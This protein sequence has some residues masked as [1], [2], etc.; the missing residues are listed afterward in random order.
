MLQDT[1]ANASVS[2]SQVLTADGSGNYTV[3]VTGGTWYLCATDATHKTSADITITNIDGSAQSGKNFA[4][5]ADSANNIPQKSSL[6]F[7]VLGDSLPTI[8]GADTGNWAIYQPLGGSLTKLGSPTVDLLGGKALASITSETTMGF[9]FMNLPQGQSLAI[10]GATITTVIKP[11]RVSTANGYQCAVSVLLGQLEL[12]VNRNTGRVALGRKDGTG[13]GIDTGYNIPDGQLSIVSYVVQPTGQITLFVNGIQQYSSNATAD[14]TSITAQQWYATDISVGKGWNGDGW[15]SFNGDIGDTFVYKTA[16][17]TTDR[18][19][20]ETSLG[21]KFGI[22][23]PAYHTLTCTA[24]TGGTI[25]PSGSQLVQDGGSQTVTI[26]ANV[27]YAI[28]EVTLDGVSQGAVASLPLTN[29]TADHTV[30]ATFRVVPQHTLTG[31]VTDKTSGLG[32]ADATVHVS[33]SPNACISSYTTATTDGSGNYTITLFEGNI[34]V[35]ASKSGYYNSA[36]LVINLNGDVPGANLQLAANARTIPSTGDIYFAAVTDN[37][38]TT[39]G[40]PIG[41]WPRIYPDTGNMTPIRTTA[42]S[43]VDN[44]PWMNGV[45]ASGTGYHALPSVTTGEVVTMNGGSIVVAVQPQSDG[46]AYGYQDVVSVLLNRLSIC[47][48]KFDNT[49]WVGRQAGDFGPNFNTGYKIPNGQ[50]TI[51]SLVCQPTGE[52]VLYA[53][54]YPIWSTNTTADMT[55]LS[56]TAWWNVDINVGMG[57]NGDTW[58]AFNGRIGDVFV[59]KTA[60]SKADRVQLQN[61]LA[62]K[63]GITLPV[64]HTITASAGANGSISPNGA[65]DVV[66][67]QDQSFT[68]TPAVDYQIDTVLVDGVNNTGAVT[69]GSYTFTTVTTDTHTIAATFKPLG[70]STFAITASAGTGGT[71]TPSGS[72]EVTPGADQAFTITADANAYYVIDQVLVDGVND[73]G[74]V[75]AGSYTFT[76]VSGTHTIAASFKKTPYGNWIAGFDVGSLTGLADDPDGDGRNNLM[77]F[78]LGGTPNNGALNAK[79]YSF[80]AVSAEF[81]SSNKVLVLTI[82]VRTNTPVFSG[83]PAVAVHPADG[84]KYTVRGGLNLSLWD[85]TIYPCAAAILPAGVTPESAGAGYEYRSFILQSSYGLPGKGFLQVKIEPNP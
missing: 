72:V 3:G 61:D 60:L 56:T 81:G 13:P 35:S 43:W 10:N 84:V 70:A 34:Y 82:A 69:A 31:R 19:A 18:I 30:V 66:A 12:C 11:V 51:L 28:Q 21:A 62:T 73:P 53:N 71:I 68:I 45:N 77:E 67:G 27:G 46:V 40:A 42:V 29:I 58:T 17:S 55:A 78:A 38:P 48:N 37:F 79:V 9:R 5:V 22:T 20:L 8:Q 7:S 63:L 57:W 41:N 4:L 26:S 44:I 49:V 33:I 83:T 24:E 1:S 6:L 2:P 85:G 14:M 16:L 47:I 80:S 25:N 65:V 74:A 39:D 52:S 32:V 64:L 50:K 36:D 76:G 23:T 59:Y 54:G 15:S 75:A